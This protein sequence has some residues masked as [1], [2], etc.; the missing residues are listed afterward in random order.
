MLRRVLIVLVALVSSLS[1]GGSPFTDSATASAA[2]FA[3]DAPVMT[4]VGAHEIAAAEAGPRP[5]GVVRA[6]AASPSVADGD[7]YTTR[8]ASVIATNTASTPIESGNYVVSHP[9][10]DGDS[11]SAASRIGALSRFVPPA[12][13]LSLR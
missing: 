1:V 6:G 9:G 7:T 8:L 10:S 4:L 12:Q 3:Y 11:R 2:P 5:L 13:A